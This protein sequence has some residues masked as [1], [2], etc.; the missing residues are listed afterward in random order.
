MIRAF[1]C[2]RYARRF[3]FDPE[4]AVRMVWLGVPFINYTV[5]VKYFTKAE[6]GISH[7]KYFRDNITMVG[8]HLRLMFEFLFYQGLR[9]LRKRLWRG[10]S[11]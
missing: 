7:F 1:S 10:R 6:G 5:A 9:L 11:F 2:T 4:I 3:D 8:L